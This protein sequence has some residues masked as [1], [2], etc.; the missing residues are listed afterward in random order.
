[1]LHIIDGHNLIPN[2]PGM[3]LSSMDD[4]M[5]LVGIL[6]E[7]SRSRRQPVEVYFDGAPEGKSGTKKFGTIKVH[8]VR[9]GL[10]A[11]EAIISRLRKMGPGAKNTT[12]VT[13]DAH[14]QTQVRASGAKIMTSKAFAAILAGGGKDISSGGK[15]D[16]AVSENE[17]NAWMKEFGG[18]PN[19]H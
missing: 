17:V 10:P 15:Q 7:F 3:S 4:E 12:V 2:I 8:F 18:D 14:I 6:Q 1:M 5:E 16:R 11:D 13:S 9:K 19:R